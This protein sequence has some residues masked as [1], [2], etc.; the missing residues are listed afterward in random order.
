MFNSDILFLFSL[1][2]NGLIL[3]HHTGGIIT[4]QQQSCSQHYLEPL[5]TKLRS[6]V[7]VIHSHLIRRTCTHSRKQ[8]HTLVCHSSPQSTVVTGE[9]KR[10][11]NGVTAR[12]LR[13]SDTISM[14]PT[15]GAREP[16]RRYGKAGFPLRFSKDAMCAR[17]HLSISI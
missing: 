10:D 11:K 1:R 13:H 17:K 15:G 5:P 16:R 4:P 2:N 6:H 3:F 9:K 7:R 12:L 14:L 8:T